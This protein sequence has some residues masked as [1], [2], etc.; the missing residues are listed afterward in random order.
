MCEFM[1]RLSPF[2]FLPFCLFAF[3]LVTVVFCVAFARGVLAFAFPCVLVFAFGLCM[4]ALAFAL[5]VAFA[6][7]FS[8]AFVQLLLA[9]AF[10]DALPW[11]CRI[12]ACALSAVTVFLASARE[13]P[14]YD[15]PF[16]SDS[17]NHGIPCSSS[18]SFLTFSM[19]V[20]VDSV[21]HDVLEQLLWVRC[22]AQ[23]FG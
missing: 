21:D 12:R 23:F 13:F 6:F 1:V 2:A 19:L 20:L 17:I 7:S 11:C 18:S 3:A 4:F 15:F 8:F 9:S 5:M 14:F 16:F 10:P 22:A